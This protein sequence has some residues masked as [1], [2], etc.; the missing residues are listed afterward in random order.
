MMR[1]GSPGISCTSTNVTRLLPIN[2]GTSCSGRRSTKAN[3]SMNSRRRASPCRARSARHGEQR[4]S[5]DEFRLV[6]RRELIAGVEAEALDPRAVDVAERRI[7]EADLRH[8]FVGD[9][10]YLVV[11]RL[12]PVAFRLGRG[13]FH[14]RVDLVVVVTRVI[15]LVLA[16]APDRPAQRVVRIE[17]L[18]VPPAQRC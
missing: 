3:R 10:L 8:F 2:T 15:G 17:R 7:E 14:Q 4:N 11:E 6:D 9:L 18:V 5:A 12:A 13:L 1:T 16:D